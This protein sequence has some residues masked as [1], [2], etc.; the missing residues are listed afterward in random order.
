MSLKDKIND[1]LKAAMKSGDKVRLTTV[2]SIRALIL[3]FEKS[4]AAHEM[5]EEDEIKMLSSAAKKRRDSIEQYE[6]G[7][8]TDL[9]D[10]EKAELTI[11]NSYLPE[12]LSE[13]ELLE[14][15]KNLAEEL[16][17]S[18]K[19]DFRILMPKAAQTFKGKADGKLIKE[20]V[21]KVLS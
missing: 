7:G 19:A 17:A 8:R 2:R 21:E 4:G 12:Q 18:T 13:D 6:N 16:G 11:L 15:I 20:T 14:G 9:A 1:D 5:T 10:K 3:E